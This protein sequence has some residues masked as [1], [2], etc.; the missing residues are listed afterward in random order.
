LKHFK[1]VGPVTTREFDIEEDELVLTYI[2]KIKDFEETKKVKLS[3][4]TYKEQNINIHM[5]KN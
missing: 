5:T 4:V 2:L 3:L 1:L